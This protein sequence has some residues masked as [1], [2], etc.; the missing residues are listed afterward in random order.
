[1]PSSVGHALTAL[2]FGAVVLPRCTHW[3]IWAA[4]AASAVLLD[5][6]AVGRPIGY[7]DV[8]WLGGHRGFTHSI[9]FGLGLS[10]VMLAM[11][12][13]WEGRFPTGLRLFMFFAVSTIAHA[14]LDMVTTYGQGVALFAPFSWARIKSHWQ[15]LHGIW[16]EITAIWIPSMLIIGLRGLRASRQQ[17][18]RGASKDLLA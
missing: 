17:S 11:N 13:R 14:L 18:A 16:P 10:T 8:Q 5:I 2:A 15:P 7:G 12:R 9:V 3:R 4:G 6:D 1:M